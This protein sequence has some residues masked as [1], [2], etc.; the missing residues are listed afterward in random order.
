MNRHREARCFKSR[1]LTIAISAATALAGCTVVQIKPLDRKTHDVKLV[2]IE[3]NDR[4]NHDGFLPMLE[5]RFAEHG[6]STRRY[7]G[8]P[9][10]DCEYT[11]QYDAHWNWDLAV[12]LTD[13]TIEIRKGGELVSRAVYHLRNKGGLDL[14]KF[15]SAEGKM[16]PVIDQ[17]L[18]EFTS[19]GTERG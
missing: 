11:A 6:I 4:V 1:L 19:I 14:G 17:M 13:A 9:S 18:A 16:Q 15:G 2:C 5:N 3:Q 12:Y 7:T 8:K 10:D